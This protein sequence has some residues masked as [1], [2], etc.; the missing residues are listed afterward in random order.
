MTEMQRPPAEIRHAD[1]LKLLK[2]RDKKQWGA[3]P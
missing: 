3:V 1:E 2:Q